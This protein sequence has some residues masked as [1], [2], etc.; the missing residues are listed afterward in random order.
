MKYIHFKCLRD[1]LKNKVTSRV[2]DFMTL[3]GIKTLDCELC[4]TKFSDKVKIKND[5][6]DLV[7]FQKPASNYI[8]LEA[9]VKEKN[10]Q[11]LIFII[12]FKNRTSFQVGRQNDS[13]N[14]LI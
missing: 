5:M 10:D 8:V 12:H 11:R 1:W 2:Y 3:H 6:Y 9:L 7:D 13:G 14:N 4:K